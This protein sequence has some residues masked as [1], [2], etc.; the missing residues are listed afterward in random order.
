MQE[1]VQALIEFDHAV[2]RLINQ[3]WHV[4][5]LDSFFL[6]I[7]DLHKIAAFKLFVFPA[8]LV[9]GVYKYRVLFLKWM[10]ALGL[11]IAVTDA[12]NYR[13]LK[14]QGQRARPAF[15]PSAGAVLRTEKSPTDPSFPSNHA[16]N[17]MAG[18]T[19][20]SAVMPALSPILF[21]IAALV[22]YSRPYLGLHFP[23]DVL[24]GALLGFCIARILIRQ[25]FRR[26]SW[27]GFPQK[28]TEHDG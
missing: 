6:S 20:L 25:V 14:A 27:F 2:F 12:F 4:A 16:I 1:V 15:V 21:L 9:L 5:W 26:I 18:A 22:A 17:T 10:L 23:L 13:V 19:V 11:T 3:T 7:S 24:V 28:A 8:L